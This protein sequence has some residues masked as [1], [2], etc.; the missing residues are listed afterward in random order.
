M[1]GRDVLR[2]SGNFNGKLNNFSLNKFWSTSKNGIK[3]IGDLRFVNAVNSERG[4]T[5]KV[6][7]RNLTAT[8][9]ELKN[10]LPN[11]LGNTFTTEF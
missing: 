2:F 11:V 7:L 9:N 5:F 3:V 1:N 6:N 10:V 8:Y 4:F